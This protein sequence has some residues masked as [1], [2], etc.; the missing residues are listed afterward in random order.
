MYSNISPVNYTP[1]EAQKG[2]ELQLHY[3]ATY[4]GLSSKNYINGLSFKSG[5]GK[6]GASYNCGFYADFGYEPWGGDWEYGYYT[7]SGKYAQFHSQN[8]YGIP[9]LNNVFVDMGI[10]IGIGT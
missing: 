7:G 4:I 5:K 1:T 2:K 8:V 9:H 3:N 10:F 6:K